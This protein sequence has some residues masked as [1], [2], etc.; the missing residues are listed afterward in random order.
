[1]VGHTHEAVD[2]FFSYISRALTHAENTM[3]G[4]ALNALIEN[5]LEDGT[6]MKVDELDWVGD[7]N[8]GDARSYRQRERSALA[9]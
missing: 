1:M 4:D 6:T 3:T 8:R 9:F 2:R 7:W 5:Y